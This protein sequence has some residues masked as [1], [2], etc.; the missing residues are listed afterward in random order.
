MALLGS[1][2][3]QKSNI[4]AAMTVLAMFGASA[5]ET[6]ISRMKDSFLKIHD[7]YLMS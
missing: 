4:A 5:R 6:S 1:V 3:T 7:L 2:L